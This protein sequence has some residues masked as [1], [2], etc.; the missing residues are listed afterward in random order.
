MTHLM[1]TQ[2]ILLMSIDTYF[3]LGGSGGG[4]DNG[5]S[6]QSWSTPERSLGGTGGAALGW[7]GESLEKGLCSSPDEEDSLLGSLG[8]RGGGI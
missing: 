1:K 8:G 7:R 6:E 2:R 5:G 4:L 3:G